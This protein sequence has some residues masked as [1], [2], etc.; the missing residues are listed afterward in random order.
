MI[1]EQIK[2]V[3]RHWTTR[4]KVEPVN[5]IEEE[6]P[7]EKEEEEAVIVEIEFDDEAEDQKLL[8]EDQDQPLRKHRLSIWV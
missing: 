2:T 6:F 8:Q 4:R 1:V 5:H 3:Y 7:L